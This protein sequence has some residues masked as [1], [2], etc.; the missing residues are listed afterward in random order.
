MF[1]SCAEIPLSKKGRRKKKANNNPTLPFFPS[2]DS[3]SRILTCN[4]L[5]RSSLRDGTRLWSLPLGLP[6]H[7]NSALKALQFYIPI[8]CVRVHVCGHVCVEIR[9]QLVVAHCSLSPHRFLRST[10]RPSGWAA[11]AFLL[12][13]L[14]CSL[15]TG[16]LPKMPQWRPFRGSCTRRCSP[17]PP[18]HC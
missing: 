8:V 9:A 11:S 18:G 6:S 16:T 3:V 7:G 17:W 13:Q 14:T 5:L 15:S 1:E 2:R 10:C 12:S 4:V